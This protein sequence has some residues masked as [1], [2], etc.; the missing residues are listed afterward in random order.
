MK[1]FRQILLA[2]IAAALG[3]LLGK[4]G[5]ETQPAPLQSQAGGSSRDFAAPSSDKSE[6]ALSSVL[7][8]LL[9]RGNF[10]EL[11]RLGTL[12][13]ALDS[14]QMRA[15]L[16]RIERLTPPEYEVFLPRLL[17]YWTKRDPQAAT[18]WM[19]P[20]LAGYA[21]DNGFA[22]GF[23]NFDTDLMQAWAKN[24]PELAVEYARGHFGTRLAGNILVTA[25]FAWP[26]KDYAHRFELLRSFPAGEERKKVIVSLCFTWG[27]MDREAALASAG[28]LPPG[29][30][31]DGALGQI[32]ARSAWKDPAAAFATVEKFGLRVPPLLASLTKATARSDPAATARWVETQDAGMIVELGG[33]VARFWAERDPAKAFAWAIE[34]GVSIASPPLRNASKARG[35]MFAGD[36]AEIGSDSPLSV[37]LKEKPE[38]TFAWLRALPAGAERD[39]NLELAI[40]ASPDE[41]RVRTLVTELSPEAAARGAARVAETLALRDF[42]PAQQWAESLSGPAREAAWAAIGRI[43]IEPRPLPLGPD[44]DAML[45]GSAEAQATGTPLKAIERALEIGDPALRRRTFDDVL[46]QVNR[47][48]IALTGGVS[49]VGT[50]D[51]EKRAVQQWLIDAKIPDEWKKPWQH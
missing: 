39:R 12:L 14:K 48:D 36:V 22:A 33:V 40:L 47:G 10:R 34:H 3:F 13:D 11:A 28:S 27:Q 50:P 16:E 30:E 19:Q 35:D 51:S 38:E 46:W 31:R 25:I 23:A 17:A 20:R 29:E 7:G 9:D 8:A 6:E 4:T 49:L 18:E 5:R 26:D 2:V 42:A 32:L 44:R 15:L 37:A 45:R 43:R 21:K 41:K 1:A 24:A